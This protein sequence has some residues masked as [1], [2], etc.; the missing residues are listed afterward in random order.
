MIVERIKDSRV[1][2]VIA[3]EDADDAV[4]LC[5]ALEAGGLE[6]AEITFRTDAAADALRIVQEEFPEFV[7]GAGTVT[8]VEEVDAA[9][10]AGAQFAVAPGLNPLV[11][12]RAQQIGLPF[13]PGVCTPSDVEAALQ[14]GCRTL[15]FFPAGA[16]G[17]ARMLKSLYGPYRHRGVEF[18][19]TG[20]VNAENLSDYLTTP[21]VI[22]VGGSWVASRSLLQDREWPRITKLASEAVRIA[23][24]R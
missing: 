8:R 12:E 2:P 14:L 4:P 16:M 13:F 6:V 3:L 15:K 19:P 21:G 9:H 10:Q 22:A 20:G 1:I 24:G 17:G 11:V 5:K 18:I 7:L 23:A